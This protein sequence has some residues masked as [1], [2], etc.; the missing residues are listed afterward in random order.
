MLFFHFAVEISL[1]AEGKHKV[2]SL[3][4]LIIHLRE[5][6]WNIKNKTG[7]ETVTDVTTKVHRPQ[8][9]WRHLFPQRTNP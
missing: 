9:V 2:M 6:F 1:S 3:L 5:N 8:R 7:G 4:M